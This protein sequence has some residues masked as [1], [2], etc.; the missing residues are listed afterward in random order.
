MQVI[1]VYECFFLCV[2]TYRC[3]YMYLD[4]CVYFYIYL[5]V[6]IQNM[7]QTHRKFTKI[8]SD[9]SNIFY[10]NKMIEFSQEKKKENR[11]S[12][13]H[14]LFSKMWYVFGHFSCRK[15]IQKQIKNSLVPQYGAMAKSSHSNPLDVPV[16]FEI[17]GSVLMLPLL[18]RT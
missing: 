2:Y 10:F 16:D 5:Q 11:R 3:M 15:F 13:I 1:H 8:M 12:L 18:N 9:L 17:L 14:L 4:T 7:F 6:Y